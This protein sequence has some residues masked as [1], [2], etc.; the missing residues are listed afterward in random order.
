[1][2]VLVDHAAAGAAG[3]VGGRVADLR[4]HLLRDRGGMADRR[5]GSAHRAAADDPLHQFRAGRAIRRGAVAD[6]V[7]AVLPA[8]H[9][10]PP[11]SRRAGARPRPRGLKNRGVVDMATLEIKTLS[12][13]FGEPRAVDDLSLTVGDGEL[14]CLL[15]PSGSGKSTVLRMMGGFEQ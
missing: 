11:L 10:G 9:P 6:A 13:L 12:R 4:Q 2:R 3:G 15:G 14:V 7:G 1:A 5:A 8:A